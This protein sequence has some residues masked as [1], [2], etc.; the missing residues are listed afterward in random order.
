MT[1]SPPPKFRLAI[2]G[3]GPIGKLLASTAHLQ[4]PRIEVLQYEGDTPPLRPGFGYGVGPQALRAYNVANEE[5]G[6]K[7]HD[8]CILGPRWMKWWHSGAEDRMI[9]DVNVPE[10]MLHGWIGRDE[11][12]ETL[13]DSIPEALGPVRYGKTLTGVKKT[14][15]GLLEL[16]FQDGTAETVNVIWACEGINSICRQVLQGSDYQPPAYSGMLCFRGKVPAATISAALG[17]QFAKEQV[18]FIGTKGWHVLT[19]PIAGGAFVNIAT[20]AVE[21]EWKRMGREYKPTKEDILAYF[22]GRNK[23]VDAMIN[24]SEHYHLTSNR[25]EG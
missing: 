6:R 24:V 16:A 4:H 2:V 15:A 8:A 23:T 5:V 19:F 13:G 9:E 14:D 25:T 12:M 21:P 22:P 17:E 10:G 7:I 3:S 18:M 1:S 20:F 11:L